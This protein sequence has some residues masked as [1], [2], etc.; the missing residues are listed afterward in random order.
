M[1]GAVEFDFFHHFLKI[2]EKSSL[3]IETSIHTFDPTEVSP[4][5][6]QLALKKG[7]MGKR[8]EPLLEEAAKTVLK[9]WNDGAIPTRPRGFVARAMGERW[10][11][12]FCEVE[13]PKLGL[14]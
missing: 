6:P 7:K 4:W 13:K 12:F 5:R 3:L 9:D 8:C 10:V 11:V 14:G 1:F 2:P